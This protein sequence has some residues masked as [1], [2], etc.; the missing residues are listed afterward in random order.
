MTPNLAAIETHLESAQY[1]QQLNLSDE[2]CGAWYANDVSALLTLLRQQQAA[3]NAIL[4]WKDRV[5][6]YRSVN[7]IAQ[8]I[9]WV[10]KKKLRGL[11]HLAQG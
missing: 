5:P 1:R 6:Y 3:L 10:V 2:E 7:G 11:T 4:I 8:D 9:P